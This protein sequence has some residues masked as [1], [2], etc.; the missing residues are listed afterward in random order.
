MAKAILPYPD[1]D[2]QAYIPLEPHN[3]HL[4]SPRGNRVSVNISPEAAAVWTR[5]GFRVEWF[6]AS[7]KLVA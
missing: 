3:A 6:A 4:V 1:P 7:G 2:S 5:Y